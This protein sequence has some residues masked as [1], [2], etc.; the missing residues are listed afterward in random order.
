MTA[1]ARFAL[2]G[3]ILLVPSS[4]RAQDPSK[5]E[6]VAA[7][8][9]AQVLV[10]NGRR[11]EAERTLAS[12]MA[13]SCPTPVREDC[14]QRLIEVRQGIP[15]VVFEWRDSAGGVVQVHRVT[16]DGQPSRDAL[17]GRPVRLDAGE[18]HLLSEAEGFAS[19]EKTFT[20]RD[21]EKNRKETIVFAAAVASTPGPVAG[22]EHPS[23]ETRASPPAV[24]TLAYVAVGLGVA[25][26]AL[27]I[28][29]GTTASS[30]NAALQKECSGNDCPPTAQHDID[31][32]RTWRDWST[33]GYAIA[34][35]GI[36]GGAI[37]FWFSA[38]KP[39]AK[40]PTAGL[41]IGP[42][43]AGFRGTF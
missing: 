40:D 21:G 8:E 2:A 6:C 4:A 23:G 14:A 7:N 24:R 31:S 15:S 16:V 19:V 5:F 10:R 22:T 12:C 26:L 41:W 13:A 11:L 1:L 32:F 30:S 42:R 28:G 33:V 29:A 18:H 27:G 36:A 37:L 25:G 3:A 39:R 20:L 43:G 38:T 34:A 9:S 35:A 17:A